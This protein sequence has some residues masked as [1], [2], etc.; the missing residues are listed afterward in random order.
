MYNRL[1]GFIEK[2]DI[3]FKNQFGFRTN[4]STDYA[5]F[6]IIDKVQKAIDDRDFSCGIF[7]D[8]SKAF[9][10]V[11]H[12]ILI[13]K[14]KYYGIRGVAIDWFISYL[15]DRNQMVTINNISSTKNKISCGVPQGSVLGPILFLLYVNDFH[16]CS[17]L[18]SFHLF[19]DDANLFCQDKN[20]SNL[21]TNINIE[22]GKVHTW[23]CINKLSLNIDKSNF[24][25]FHAPQR[26]TRS[27]IDL[28]INN[29]CLK[30]E[31]CIKYLGILIDSN[32]NWKTHIDYIAK[33]ITRSIGILSKI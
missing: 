30:Q 28:F 15:S 17:D 24:V 22:L 9:D 19:A 11:N 26:K 27:N 20:F 18:F 32:L 8:F 33:K 16:T 21:Q 5:I 7:L 4:H 2:N 13:D 1:I 3:F 6:S 29:K 25:I 31:Y 23:L 14:L 12:N 10:T